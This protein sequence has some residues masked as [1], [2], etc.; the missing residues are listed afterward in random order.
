MAALTRKH[1][2]NKLQ[3][4]T[5]KPQQFGRRQLK[6]IETGCVRVRDCRPIVDRFNAGPMERRHAHR[7]GL[8]TG[9]DF[10]AIELERAERSAG[11]ADRGD[12]GVGRQ[13]G[14]Q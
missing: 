6:F 11:V 7:A 2:R 12:L 3:L 8:A 9:V 10:A 1:I 5:A 4:T 13:N 14:R